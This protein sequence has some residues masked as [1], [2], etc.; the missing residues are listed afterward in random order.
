M[1][2]GPGDEVLFEH[3]AK[4]ASDNT[5]PRELLAALG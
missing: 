1:V 5:E 3:M 2:I 4:D